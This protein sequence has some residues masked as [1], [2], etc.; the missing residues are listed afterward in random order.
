MA[1]D[2]LSEFQQSSI[3]AAGNVPT[4]NS[5]R[6]WWK[7][8]PVFRSR[9]SNNPTIQQD[10]LD[11][12]AQVAN[13]LVTCQQTADAV[14]DQQKRQL[15][16]TSSLVV[17]Q[18]W[19]HTETQSNELLKSLFAAKKQLDL[20]ENEVNSVDRKCLSETG[21]RSIL[22]QIH[23]NRKQLLNLVERFNQ[24]QLK[25]RQRK[26]DHLRRQLRVTGEEV[27]DERLEQLLDGPGKDQVFTGE[28]LLETEAA[29]QS[30]NLAE[31]RFRQL[32]QVEMSIQQL[33]ELFLQLSL[34]VEQQ[35][36][37]I[38]SIEVHVFK[39]TDSTSKGGA[40]LKNA[41]R[42]RTLNLKTRIICGSVVAVLVILLIIIL[43]WQFS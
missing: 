18:T 40:E 30:L 20:I 33:H 34:L 15:S 35:G 3:N 19:Q 22:T 10:F 23:F 28:I 16:V 32:H 39:A 41:A 17:N 31:D 43:V 2:R 42:L 29:R 37:T 38:D 36:E 12:V 25:F 11:R 5:V 21:H 26:K 4:F 7:R 24:Q 13:T 27:D 1:R 9:D 6:H 14:S 8:T